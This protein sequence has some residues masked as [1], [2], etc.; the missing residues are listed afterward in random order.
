MRFT[1]SSTTGKVLASTVILGAAAS[2]AGLG[3]FGTFTSTTS[4][5]AQVDSGKVAIALGAD[6]TATNRLNVAAA[7]LVPGDTVQ[8]AVQLSNAAGQQD[9]AGIT[10]T[11]TAPTSS[12][13]DTDPTN[14]LQLVVDACSV[15]WTEGGTAPAYTYAC[16]G[17]TKSV[18]TSR[19]VKGAN[20]PLANLVSTTAGNTDNLRVT[21]AFPTAAGDTFQNQG[22]ALLFTFGGAQRA[23]S[24]R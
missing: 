12:L 15:P 24:A 6:G 3:T 9:L 13:L 11:T 23:G 10:L 22:S 18:L 4:A 8:R 7:K 21:L 20:M 1:L 16:P 19:A 5:S 14:G 2:V 17:V